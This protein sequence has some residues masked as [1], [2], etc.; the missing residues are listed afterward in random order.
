M[1]LDFR[2]QKLDNLV[3]FYASA[4]RDE[5]IFEGPFAIG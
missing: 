1:D 4:N 3:L 5:S 2:G